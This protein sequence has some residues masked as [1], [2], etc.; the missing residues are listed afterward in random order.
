MLPWYKLFREGRRQ[1]IL[2]SNPSGSWQDFRLILAATGIDVPEEVSCLGTTNAAGDCTQGSVLKTSDGKTFQWNNNEINIIFRNG[3]SSITL[4]MAF[5]NPGPGQ[6]N[7][8]L[9]CIPNGDWG[10][11]MCRMLTPGQQKVMCRLSRECYKMNL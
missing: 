5:T 6:E 10:E 2:A 11:K 3:T 9:Y 7:E 1:Y 4:S 8:A